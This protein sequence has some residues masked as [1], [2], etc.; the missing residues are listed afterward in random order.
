M[1]TNKIKRGTVPIV[2]AVTAL[3]CAMARIGSLHAAT[4]PVTSTADDG[5]A[6]TLRA[7]LARAVNGDTIDATGVSGTVLLASGELVV[8]NNVVIHGPGPANLTVAANH[9]SRVFIITP[10]HTVTMVGL[11]ITQGSATGGSG[12]GI[13]NDHSSLTVSNC[14]ISGNSTS[15][16]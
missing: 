8:S 12:G 16:L 13:L 4:I 11:T 6:G 15:I 1:K 5:G 7:A 14:V 9:L 2:M 3:L 10:G